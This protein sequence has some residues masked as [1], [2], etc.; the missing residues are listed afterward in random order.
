MKSAGRAAVGAVALAMT[1]AITA[2]EDDGRTGILTDE[3]SPPTTE[4][5]T[6]TT[7]APTT[8][9]APA[10]PVAPPPV[11]DVPGNPAAA[12]ALAAWAT[13][14]VSLDVDALTNACW[15]MPPTTI[16]DR[17]SDLPAI[18]TAI[19]APGVDGQYAVTWS[20]GGLSVA[21]KRSEIASGYACP[22]VFPAGQSNFYT[23]ADASHAVVRFLSRATGRPVNTR[24]VETFYPLICP[25]NSP[26]D[27]DGT[28]ATGQP[29]LKLDPN[30]L[31][32]IKSF[33]ADAATVTPVRGDY[34]RVTLPV[35]DGT[36][37]SR[38]MQFTLSIGPEGYCLGAAT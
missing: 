3:P 17:Y 11:G 34:V 1:L 10:T 27:P 29:P 32:G 7:L 24:D 38:P 21:A 22:F 8:T 6:T 4:T 23:A 26:W 2:C 20:G 9:T 36:G 18:L 16:A 19:A 28:G 35:S 5:T 12:P 14:L 37:N 15:T 31:A 13:D 25:G 30:Q 33:D